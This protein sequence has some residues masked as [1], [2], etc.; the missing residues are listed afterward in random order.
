MASYH[1][2]NQ[3]LPK[4]LT[5]L[6]LEWTGGFFKRQMN[7]VIQELNMRK[8]II[9]NTKFW[10]LI[11]EN[12]IWA[13]GELLGDIDIADTNTL[14]SESIYMDII[15]ELEEATPE[16]WEDV[17]EIL[18]HVSNLGWSLYEAIIIIYAFVLDEPMTEN[19]T[20]LVE[21]FIQAHT[22]QVNEL[23]AQ[24]EARAAA[25]AHRMTVIN[26]VVTPYSVDINGFLIRDF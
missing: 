13:N 19:E 25:E 17:E 7:E 8:F 14:I 2:L 21:Q 16:Q 6:T 22:H 4:E 23:L 1:T 12:T 10:E 24:E 20:Q 18:I 11:E 5:L 15:E 26:M 9:A 3:F